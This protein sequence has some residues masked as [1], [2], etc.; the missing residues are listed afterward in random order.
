MA[1]T[2]TVP[3]FIDVESKI[4]GSLTIRQFLISLSGL[5]LM[6]I[7]FKLFSFLLFAVLSVFTFIIFGSFA[8]LKING[9]PFHFFVLNF[10]QTARSTSLRVWNHRNKLK[11]EEEAP[12][13]ETSKE[14]KE[15]PRKPKLSSSKLSEVALIVDTQGAYR[16]EKNR[17]EEEDTSSESSTN[18]QKQS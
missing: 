13:E 4:I 18:S 1:K 3:Q 5:I 7:F 9:R 6:F 17:E 12:V 2:F 15:P 14:K 8:F 10:I 11:D 16:G